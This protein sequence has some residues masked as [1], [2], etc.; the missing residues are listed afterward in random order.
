MNDVTKFNNRFENAVVPEKVPLEEIELLN[1][2]QA[3]KLTKIE[4]HVLFDAMDKY[5]ASKGALGLPFVVLGGRSRRMIRRVSL[6]RWLED[7]ERR[8]I[9]A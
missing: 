9:Y 1:G 8:S 6:R 3:A 7:L 5:K 4:R 2:G